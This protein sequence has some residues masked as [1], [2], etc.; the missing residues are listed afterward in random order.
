MNTSPLPDRLAGWLLIATC[1]FVFLAQWS[2]ESI[3]VGAEI[4]TV[5]P[6]VLL[7]ARRTGRMQTVFLSVGC[8]LFA[9]TLATRADWLTLT[10][11]ALKT[12]AFIAAFFT[13]TTALRYAATSSPAV[14][15]CGRLLAEQ[16]P[17][18]RYGALTTG[19]HLFTL[20]LNYGSIALLGA[21]AEE[22][23]RREDNPHI[24]AIRL[25]R[26]LLAIQR[27]FASALTWSP[28]AFATAI[29]ISFVPDTTWKEILGPS[30][31]SSLILAVGG[32]LLDT[33]IKPKVSASPSTPVVTELSWTSIWPLPVLLVVLGVSVGG[34]H[35]ATGVRA[36]AAVILV[37]PIIS[38][39]WIAFQNRDDAPMR[40]VRERTGLFVTRQLLGYR[41]ELVLLTMAGFIGGLGGHLL[42][43]F[44]LGAGFDLSSLPGWL[45]LIGLLWIIPAA[46]QLGMNP[47]LAVSL[48]APLLPE[49]REVGIDPSDIAVAMTAGWA[50]A[51]ASSPFTASTLVV[52][53]FGSVTARYVGLVWNGLYV[54]V[55][56]LALSAWVAF[57]AFW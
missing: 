17:G 19:G 40:H 29:S 20:V 2:G 30:L 35:L 43:P 15:E 23:S 37:V 10:A 55:T 48:I 3:L 31:V 53:G 1:F 38:L 46:G 22:S 4:V 57:L 24:R 39:A 47:I 56:G 49:A 36:T 41:N 54:V 5:I 12:T 50:L 11:S 51:A 25:R 7:L 52:G 42:S 18:R 27:G 8:I 28:L 26:M 14:I 9:V 44:V 16:P 21:L 13:A 34:I 6:A 45:L 32:W 33:L